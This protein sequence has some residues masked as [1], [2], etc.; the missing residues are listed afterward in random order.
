ML[1]WP[2]PPHHKIIFIATSQLQFFYIINCNVNI[3]YARCRICGPVKRLFDTQ[4]G[5]DPQVESHWTSGIPLNRQDKK[6]AL[7]HK[8]TTDSAKKP[9]QSLSWRHAKNDWKKLLCWGRREL[10]AQCGILSETPLLSPQTLHLRRIYKE[11]W[12]RN[13]VLSGGNKLEKISKEI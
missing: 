7:M 6:T 12:K 5:H 13:V 11:H 4:R 3:L 8:N 10:K 9:A 1:G 2:P